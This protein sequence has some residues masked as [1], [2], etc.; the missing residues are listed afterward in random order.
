MDTHPRNQYFQQL[1]FQRSLPHILHKRQSVTCTLGSEKLE[2]QRGINTDFW[3]EGGN[4]TLA[5][6]V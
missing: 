1:Q 6:L 4:I 2:R 3:L 5:M